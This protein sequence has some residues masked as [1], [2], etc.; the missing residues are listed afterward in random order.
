LNDPTYAVA[1]S[2]AVLPA[3]RQA[4]D[5]RQHGTSQLLFFFRSTSEKRKQKEGKVPLRK[6]HMGT[7]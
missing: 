4:Q 5:E 3:L 7:A 2:N 6:L 1:L